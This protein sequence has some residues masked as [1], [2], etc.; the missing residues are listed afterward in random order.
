MKSANLKKEILQNSTAPKIIYDIM[1][2]SMTLLFSYCEAKPKKCFLD[3]H[4]EPITEYC[5][6]KFPKQ[7]LGL[8]GVPI[9]I[10]EPGLCAKS[11]PPE[12]TVFENPYLTF[13]DTFETFGGKF[14][15]LK[16]LF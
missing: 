11:P 8:P 16:K 3:L 13:V 12:G 5:H 6:N 7:T 14:L 2:S 9:P 15:P 1:I 10:T 4:C